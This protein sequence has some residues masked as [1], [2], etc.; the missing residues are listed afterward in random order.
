MCISKRCKDL[1]WTLL[2][3][4]AHL[5]VNKSNLVLQHQIQH[6]LCVQHTTRTCTSPI[7]VG[8]QSFSRPM[9]MT[10]SVKLTLSAGTRTQGVEGVEKGA[11]RAQQEQAETASHSPKALHSDQPT[12]HPCWT[13]RSP[14]SRP[15]P[16]ASWRRAGEGELE[17]HLLRWTQLLPAAGQT[18]LRA[19]SPPA[20]PGRCPV[21][22][23]R[24]CPFPAWPHPWTHAAGAWNWSLVERRAVETSPLPLVFFFSR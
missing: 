21:P 6:H 12:T 13:G 9:G 2:P 23:L 8:V 16:A 1:V 19:A 17:L 22:R 11:G 14:G 10:A 18:S 5:L 20:A 3:C 24:H 4:C 15:A 7:M